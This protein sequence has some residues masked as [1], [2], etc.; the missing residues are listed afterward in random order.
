MKIVKGKDHKQRWQEY[1]N[2]RLRS[3][4]DSPQSFLDDVGE[5]EKWDEEEWL[6][7]IESMYFVEVDGE[8]VGMIGAF[9]DKR[10]KLNHIM[11]VVSFFVL[12]EFRGK[13]FGRE[14]LSKVIRDSKQ[15]EN[16][17]KLELGVITTQ[18]KAYQ[19]YLSLGFKMVGEQKFAVK[20]QKEYYD[21]YLMELYLD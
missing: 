15:I 4:K 8:W 12:P 5:T 18:E 6:R 19:L 11:K 9:Q 13:G 2:L 10:S 14:L 17:K 7:R 3:L 1:R 21:E 20:V 16:V